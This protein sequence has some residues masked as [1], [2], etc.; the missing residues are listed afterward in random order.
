MITG[1]GQIWQDL[2]PVCLWQPADEKY[3]YPKSK[4]ETSMKK[5]WLALALVLALV[6]G[7]GGGAGARPGQVRPRPGINKDVV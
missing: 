1:G 3:R 7:C 4:E 5:Q 2:A 6:S